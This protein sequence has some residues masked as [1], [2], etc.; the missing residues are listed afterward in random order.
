MRCLHHLK[1]IVVRNLIQDRSCEIVLHKKNSCKI[2]NRNIFRA[3]SV[4]TSVHE[5]EP[6]A[7][8]LSSIKPKSQYNTVQHFVDIKQVR[9]LF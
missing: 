1:T 5:K 2:L 4:T 6:T 7:K 3:L 9:I 8:A